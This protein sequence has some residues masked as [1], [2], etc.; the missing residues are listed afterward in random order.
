[1]LLMVDI[2]PD[3]KFEEEIKQFQAEVQN[4]PEPVENVGP[5]PATEINTVLMP[6][7]PLQNDSKEKSI[8]RKWKVEAILI[9]LFS[10]L[11]IGFSTVAAL[12]TFL[13]SENPNVKFFTGLFFGI[14]SLLG[15]LLIKRLDMARIVVMG[16][17]V[18]LIVL[19]FFPGTRANWLVIIAVVSTII[20]LS[21]DGIKRHFN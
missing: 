21:N 15:L 8:A 18:L 1:M 19:Q 16:L 2:Q 5:E 17:M 9:T 7:H 11:I 12:P 10:F 4:K 20:F 13:N 14:P 3:S 6:T